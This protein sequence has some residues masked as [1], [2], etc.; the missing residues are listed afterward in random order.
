M[1]YL[2]EGVF[3]QSNWRLYK[4]VWPVEEESRSLAVIGHFAPQGTFL[5]PCELQARWAVQVFKVRSIRNHSDS[6]PYMAL[7]ILGLAI[8]SY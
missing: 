1:P 2:D 7:S 6:G 8:S 3:D 4:Y 5:T